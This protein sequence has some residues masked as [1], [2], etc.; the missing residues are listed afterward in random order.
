MLLVQPRSPE[1]T[2]RVFQIPGADPRLTLRRILV[3]Y[4]GPEPRYNWLLLADGEGVRFDAQKPRL[5]EH[6]LEHGHEYLFGAA[7]STVP[8]PAT[9]RERMAA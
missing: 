7:P 4:T 5:I 9:V 6:A 2:N 1:H 3:G 8:A